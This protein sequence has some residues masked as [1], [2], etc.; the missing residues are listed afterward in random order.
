MKMAYGDHRQVPKLCLGLSKAKVG[1]TTHIDQDL[2][3]GTDPEE[4]TG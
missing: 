2:C 4:I 1:S 3:I